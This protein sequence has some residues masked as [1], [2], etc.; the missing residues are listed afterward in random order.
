MLNFL[1]SAL[2]LI[3]CC[4]RVGYRST[5]TRF[6]FESVRCLGWYNTTPPLVDAKQLFDRRTHKSVDPFQYEHTYASPL[7][8]ESHTRASLLIRFFFFQRVA[9][10]GAHIRAHIKMIRRG[11][12]T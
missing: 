8:T 4:F 11:R 6:A 12:E 5:R 2:A 10:R 7:T 1:P 9:T 3:V